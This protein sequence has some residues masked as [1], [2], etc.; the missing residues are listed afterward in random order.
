MGTGQGWWDSAPQRDR[1]GTEVSE[2]A[3]LDT[4]MPEVEGAS[5]QSPQQHNLWLRGNQ[6]RPGLPKGNRQWLHPSPSI[7]AGMEG[8]GDSRNKNDQEPRGKETKA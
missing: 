4:V 3:E 1:A 5:Q 6:S 2:T 7:A 8:P